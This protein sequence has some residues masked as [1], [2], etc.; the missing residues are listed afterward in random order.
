MNDLRQAQLRVLLLLGVFLLTPAAAAR[1]Q[2]TGAQGVNLLDLLRERAELKTRISTLEDGAPASGA[3][4]TPLT[5]K[6]IL[7]RLNRQLYAKDREIV[8][9]FKEKRH[10]SSGNIKEDLDDVTANSTGQLEKELQ[11]IAEEVEKELE[12]VGGRVQGLRNEVAGLSAKAAEVAAAPRDREPPPPVVPFTCDKF[13]GLVRRGD[14]KLP[15]GTIWCGKEDDP[16]IDVRGLAKLAAPVLWFSPTEPLIL[17]KHGSIQIPAPL[18][19]RD[20]QGDP[21]GTPVVYYRVS[22][23][24]RTS[25]AKSEEIERDFKEHKIRLSQVEGLTIRYYFYYPEDVG[26]GTH[27]HDLEFVKMFVGVKRVNDAAEPLPDGAA[28]RAAKNTLL[29]VEDVYGG[30]HGV[31]WYYNWLDLSRADDVSLPITVLVEEGKHASSPDRDGNGDYSPGFDV[32]RRYN[33]AWG[34]RDVIGSGELGGSRYQ[35]HMT[36]RRNSDHRVMVRPEPGDADYL[37]RANLLLLYDGPDKEKLMERRPSYKLVMIDPDL[38]GKD[39]LCK[40]LIE[41]DAT[42]AGEKT[43]QQAVAQSQGIAAVGTSTLNK[44]CEDEKRRRGIIDLVEREKF[45][46][47]LPEVDEKHGRVVR[48]A[49]KGLGADDIEEGGEALPISY[50][51][52]RGSGYSVLPPFGRFSIPAIGGY[53]VPKMNFIFGPE[54]RLSIEGMYTTSISRMVDWYA[55]AGAE[56]VRQSRASGFENR[57]VSEGGVR[58]RVKPPRIP[59][60]PFVK[61]GPRLKLPFLG[62]RIGV[63]A[64]GRDFRDHR[65]VI[66]AGT[67]A[68]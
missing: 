36:K 15:S 7:L 63:R 8:A 52:D 11:A 60:F 54:R 20:V 53:A 17:G 30:A 14:G 9:L 24:R 34:V 56:W 18:N 10:L 40:T 45:D 66:E 26:F 62:G 21:E 22:E 44:I 3:S 31:T 46:K 35:G 6:L 47:A 16:F 19:D 29:V 2:E 64:N 4:N 68:F 57:F 27:R 51:F 58:F 50:R 5:R 23:I 25:D 39:N 37:T 42:E 41:R 38:H 1:A 65:L 49:M 48:A 28:G 13:D 33:D 32:N 12:T 59:L 43:A 55:T 67:G 61:D